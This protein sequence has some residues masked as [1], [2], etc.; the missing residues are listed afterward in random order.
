MYLVSR[1]S[2]AQN[3]FFLTPPSPQK[4]I[5]FPNIFAV[6]NKLVPVE[7]KRAAERTR[8]NTWDRARALVPLEQSRTIPLSVTSD[9]TKRFNIIDISR[10][11]DTAKR[12]NLAGLRAVS[13]FRCSFD[14][15]LKIDSRKTILSG[16]ARIRVELAQS[17]AAAATKKAALKT[18]LAILESR[19]S[20]ILAAIEKMRSK[21]ESLSLCLQQIR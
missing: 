16:A 9:T 21:A 1:M 2:N 11:D 8:A 20:G 13:E 18:K 15:Q 17:N 14:E 10:I 19:R 6:L 7:S 4:K 3:L 5:Y 12:F